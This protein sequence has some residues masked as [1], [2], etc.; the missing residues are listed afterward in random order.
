[1]NIN[2]D[3][4]SADRQECSVST[5]QDENGMP[6]CVKEGKHF[7]IKGISGHENRR[8]WGVQ[9]EVDI[10]IVRFLF[11]EQVFTFLILK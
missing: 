3:N 11:L 9:L 10:R 2:P 1:M 5:Q 7:H 4:N 6:F 8:G